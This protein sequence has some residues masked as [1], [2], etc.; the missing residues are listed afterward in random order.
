MSVS[1]SNVRERHNGIIEYRLAGIGGFS[2]A[3][4]SATSV[5]TWSSNFFTTRALVGGRVH[6]ILV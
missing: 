2:S 3:T 1:G 5:I 4:L 6:H